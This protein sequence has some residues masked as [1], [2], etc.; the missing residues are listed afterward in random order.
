[1]TDSVLTLRRASIALVAAAFALGGCDT[2]QI[3]KRI[4]YKS[5]STAP[6]LELPP[7]L[8]TPRYDDRYSVS[9]ASGLAATNPSGPCGGVTWIMS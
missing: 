4:D 6:A 5:T 9:P 2:M 7:D 1:M 3:T 8:T